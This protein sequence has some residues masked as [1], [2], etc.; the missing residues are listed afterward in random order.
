MFIK[1][2]DQMDLEEVDLH[3]HGNEVVENSLC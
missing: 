1:V 2:V 3:I